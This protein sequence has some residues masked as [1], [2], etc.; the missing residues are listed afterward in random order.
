MLKNKKVLIVVNNF[1]L[2]LR[3]LWLLL[4]SPKLLVKSDAEAVDL[5]RF[6]TGAKRDL[7][8]FGKNLLTDMNL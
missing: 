3:C 4:F 6:V 2:L 7:Y 5:N 8:V 1:Q